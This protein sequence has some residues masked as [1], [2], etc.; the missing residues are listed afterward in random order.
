MKRH[1]VLD[2]Q[3]NAHPGRT[4]SIVLNIIISVCNKLSSAGGPIR[5]RFLIQTGPFSPV[6]LGNN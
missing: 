3:V 4:P 6:K 5:R 1:G 2:T